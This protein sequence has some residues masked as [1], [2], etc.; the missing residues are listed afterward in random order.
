MVKSFMLHHQADFNRR[1]FLKSVT[2]G[3]GG[4]VA[5]PLQRVAGGGEPPTAGKRPS[6]PRMT[7][8]IETSMF[9]HP[10]PDAFALIR[11]A[12][13]R[14]VELGGRHFH[15]AARS[16]QTL[17]RLRSELKDADLTPVAAFIVHQ[18]SSTDATRRRADPRVSAEATR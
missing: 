2:W 17:D 5:C 4:L 11:K 3:T 13:Y 15:A 7:L 18:I 6:E 10:A 16:K 14:F 12:G 9:R 1:T 8:A